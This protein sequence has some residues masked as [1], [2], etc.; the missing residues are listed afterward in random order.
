[1]LDIPSQVASSYEAILEQSS[2][3]SS[4][5][6]YYKRWLRFYFDFCQKYGFDPH[7]KYS[8]PEFNKKL[9][10]KNQS[11]TLRRQAHHA[12]T[13]YFR[14]LSSSLDKNSEKVTQVEAD[15]SP[16]TR[17]NPMQSS[18]ESNDKDVTTQ[19][20][21]PV[22]DNTG[23]PNAYEC[24]QYSESHA[25]TAD[26]VTQPTPLLDP[27]TE[28]PVLKP[29]NLNKEAT[30]NDRMPQDL[31]QKGSSWVWIYETLGSA[32]KVR[33]Y[34]PK[35]FEAYRSWIRSLQQFT[36]SKDPRLLSMEDVKAFLSF[37][38][39]E[40]KVSASSQNQA[41]N[42]LL[43]VFRHVLE[44]EFGQVEGVVR[45]KRKP[46]IPVVLSRDEVDRLI[47]QLEA[48]Y[49]LVARVLYGCGLRLFECMK[50]RV[51][52]LDFD[53]MRVTV[54]DGKGK[55]DRTVPMPEALVEDLKSQI[56]SV[57][58]L[59]QEDISSKYAG[60][61]LP[62]S[63][64]RKYPNAAKELAWQWIFP[65]KTLTLVPKTGES[66]RYHLHDSHVQKAIKRAVQRA[67]IAKRATPHTLRHSFASHLLLANYDIRT[68]QELLGH[69]DLKTTMIYTHTVKSSTL[70]AAKSP[71][72]F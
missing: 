36:K 71:L 17:T 51:Q 45:A 27:K 3:P 55:K 59:H 65:A 25:S 22:P 70:K 54:H 57:S 15:K 61:F 31:K 9:R 42:A 12:V 11:E 56:E 33:H 62:D 53:L 49:D 19:E 69:S 66:R 60:C 58:Q 43:F 32:I 29:S 63:L 7:D 1:M 46:Y 28:P 2:V 8:F 30:E 13:L 52:D 41:F 35:T 20:N 23:W 44:K 10:S 21:E 34:S 4:H 24:S 14:L 64:E 38:A 16:S 48:P 6:G 47:I 72:D 40:R 50:L 5:R 26:C 68:I 18:D 67:R 39:V 37:L